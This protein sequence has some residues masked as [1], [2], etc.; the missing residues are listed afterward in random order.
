MP[1]HNYNLYQYDTLIRK[2]RY[3]ETI[4]PTDDLCGNLIANIDSAFKRTNVTYFPIPKYS[5]TRDMSRLPIQDFML[6]KSLRHSH[7]QT[8]WPLWKALR[9][10]LLNQVKMSLLRELDGQIE[11]FMTLQLD[12]LTDYV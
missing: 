3:L 6:K 10:T 1:T 12:C 2:L 8:I 9:R 5:F 7:I 4:T 11:L